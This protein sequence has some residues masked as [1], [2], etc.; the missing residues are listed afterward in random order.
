ME[1]T[2]LKGIGQKRLE[3][4]NKLEIFC[5]EDLIA[6]LPQRYRDLTVI[7]KINAATVNVPSLF[8]VRVLQKPT[9]KFP[10]KNF[11]IVTCEIEDIS[12]RAQAIWFNQ[13]Y[14]AKSIEVDTDIYLYGAIEIKQGKRRIMNPSIE[15]ED[16][17][18]IVPVYRLPSSSGINQKTM[19][20]I[21]RQAI[22]YCIKNEKDQ[23]S[24]E[25]RAKHRLCTWEYA[26]ENIHFPIND[27]ALL[28]ARRRLCFE[29]LI[30]IQIFI[31]LRKK[32]NEIEAGKIFKI[33]ESDIASFV[34]KLP[35]KLTNK[36]I[37]CLKEIYNDVIS[38]KAMN[39]LVQGDVGSG[40]TIVAIISMLFAVLNGGQAALMAP[41]EIL[42]KQHYDQL[43]DF[44]GEE[45]V[46][47]LSGSLTQREHK[48]E[49][50]RIRNG[51]AKYIV[52]TNALIQK[53]VEYNNLLLIIT[54][55]QHRFGVAQRARFFAKGNSPHTLVMSATPIPRTLS[56]IVFGDLDI[57]IID[58]LPPGR[59]KISTSIIFGN[60]E[61]DML[62]YIKNEA[63]NGRQ[64]YF[65]CP[66]IE[67]DEES[68]LV[69]AEGLYEELLENIFKDIPIA[70]LHGKMTSEEK[71]D[72]MDKFQKGEVKAL[73]ST[74]VIEVGV[75]VKNATIMVIYGAE[76]F[77]LAQLHQLRGRVGRSNL[78]SYC[79]LLTKSNDQNSLERLKIMT[80]TNNGF[81]IAQ[82]DYDL[83]GPGDYLGKRQ[84]GV[85]EARFSYALSNTL[86]L[87]ETQTVVETEILPE[88]SK[89]S[90][91]VESINKK[92]NKEFNDIAY[93]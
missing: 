40:K 92:F 34:N 22:D 66:L 49:L 78:K 63:L 42:A 74:T 55:E 13:P 91:L 84:S 33:N 18:T 73:I 39:R 83:R 27:Q 5:L 17:L 29:E 19:R 7:E 15:Q 4:L 31:K 28:A 89:F 16:E 46:A 9:V 75:N 45:N 58:E 12:G 86:L 10:R 20:N 62:E 68:P 41:T 82:Y 56:L 2:V 72:V 53:S 50:E 57:S 67:E 52:G 90:S 71:N 32:Q 43:V 26:I 36:Q 59:Q 87:K 38:G 11:S 44:F 60:R 37:K 47:F 69:S 64:A 65:V 1:L 77:G 70:L 25:F 85:A 14:I 8:K 3:S 61:K 93:N 6:Y 30:N 88:L 81:E 54:D 51:E 24:S 21:I 76:R 80:K 23:F 79:F 48:I 35:Y